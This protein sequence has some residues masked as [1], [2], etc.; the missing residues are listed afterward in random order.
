MNLSFFFQQVRCGRR[1]RVQGASA[2][3]TRMAVLA[4]GVLLSACAVGPDYQ[5]PEV[6]V[7]EGYRQAEGWVLLES[8]QAALP[9]AWWRLFD[10]E[11]L[12]GLMPELEAANQNLR[13][14]EAQYRQAVALLSG[15]R[16][17]LYPTVDANVSTTRSGAGSAS[18]GA[19]AASQHGLGASVSWEVDVWGRVRRTVESEQAGAQA[20]EADLAATRLS[21]QSTLAQTYFRIR[22]A[23]AERRFLAQTVQAYERTLQIAQHRYSAGLVSQADVASARAQLENARVQWLALGRQRAQYE[24][25]MA[26]LLGRA[27]SAFRLEDSSVSVAVPVIPLSLPSMLLTRRP[28]VVAAERRVAAA[29]AQIGVAQ[30]AWFPTLTLSAQGGYRSGEWAQWLTAP[31]SYWSLGPMLAQ[32]IFDGGARQARVEQARAGYEAQAAAYR[33]TVLDA[34]REVEDYLVQVEGLRREQAVQARGLAAARE[35]LRLYTNQ[36]EAGMIDYLSVAQ[37][38]TTALVAERT[39]LALERDRL[40]ASVQLMAALGGGWESQPAGSA[41]SGN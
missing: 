7:G 38:E 22:A 3:P 34:L 16:A 19:G 33:Q 13:Q 35:S 17:N 21:L 11:T 39:A 28:D 32:A 37:V 25:A 10:D 8:S 14:A 41:L 31:F 27:P 24:N 1:Q 36:Y 30:T 2:W 12:S 9:D 20:S 23:D 18:T 4:C 26:V 29:N 40:L 5:T 15:A 6:A